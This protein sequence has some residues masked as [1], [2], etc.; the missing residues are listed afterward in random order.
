MAK[1]NT[2]NQVQSADTH[3]GTPAEP[4]AAVSTP[5]ETLTIDTGE[6]IPDT[7]QPLLRTVHGPMVHPFTNVVFNGE[8]KPAEIDSWVQSQIDAGKMVVVQ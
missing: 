4:V 2:P 6:G 1:N 7:A 3:S 5:P 8:P